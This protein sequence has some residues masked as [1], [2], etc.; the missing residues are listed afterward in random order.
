MIKRFLFILALACPVALVV[1][2]TSGCAQLGTPSA[3]QNEVI[4]LKI[5]GTSAKASIDSAAK[6][7]AAGQ[8]NVAQW[9]AVSTIYDHKFIPAFQVA[10]NA[11]H[12]DLSTIAS[13]DLINLFGQLAALVASYIPP[14]PA[15]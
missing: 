14:P 15:K 7:L 12:S 8:I 6:L 1:A 10:V 9:T 2:F 4:T 5:I 3:K 11:A 13:P